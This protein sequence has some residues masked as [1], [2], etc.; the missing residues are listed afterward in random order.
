MQTI[1]KAL[2]L[3]ARHEEFIAWS[4]V[5]YSG[6]WESLVSLSFGLWRK[7][8]LRSIRLHAIFIA[9][10]EKRASARLHHPTINNKASDDPMMDMICR[11][12]R[13]NPSFILMLSHG[14]N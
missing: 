4:I 3:R 1:L 9:V 10:K 13:S 5:S 12:P 6:S 14:P 7:V 8:V 11:I 2:A